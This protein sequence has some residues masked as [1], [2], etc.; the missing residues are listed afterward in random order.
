M[1]LSFLL[2][3]V[4]TRKQPASSPGGQKYVNRL[5]L[6]DGPLR[7]S[8]LSILGPGSPLWEQGPP[9]T[10]GGDLPLLTA[11]SPKPG[12]PHHDSSLH[13]FC[14]MRRITESPPPSPLLLPVCDSDASPHAAELPVTVPGP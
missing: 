5:S 12:A 13:W 10:L 4:E 1:Q 11:S 7:G 2:P 3:T 8:G 6:T 9:A 14:S